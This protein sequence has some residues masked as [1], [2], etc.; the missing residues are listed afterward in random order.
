MG[1]HEYEAMVE[2]EELVDLAWMEMELARLDVEA[3]R[4]HPYDCHCVECVMESAL[5][6]DNM[7]QQKIKEAEYGESH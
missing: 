5:E 2:D 4:P 1:Q 7:A 6:E 3:N